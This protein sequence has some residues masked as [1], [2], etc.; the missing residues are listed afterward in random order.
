MV[1]RP[2]K[3]VEP[4]LVSHRNGRT[5][6]ERPR[7][8]NGGVGEPPQGRAPF[9]LTTSAGGSQKLFVTSNFMGFSGIRPCQ[10][11]TSTEYFYQTFHETDCLL[12]LTVSTWMH[13]QS[14]RYHLEDDR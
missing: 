14:F 2:N 3:A 8:A 10:K 11:K 12:Q 7:S 1:N 13:V 4:F 5:H 9:T 6:V